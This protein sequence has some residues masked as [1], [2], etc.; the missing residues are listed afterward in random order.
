MVRNGWMNELTWKLWT[1]GVPATTL[2]DSGLQRL[3]KHTHTHTLLT[4]DQFY[5]S[6]VSF[7]QSGKQTPAEEL[8]R[9]WRSP[10][11][12]GHHHN[13]HHHRRHLHPRSGLSSAP[14]VELLSPADL[15]E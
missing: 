2:L 3:H 10:S 14:D 4:A 1:L 7:S 12:S 8:G 5:Y 13:H 15:D 11:P 6:Q 9:R